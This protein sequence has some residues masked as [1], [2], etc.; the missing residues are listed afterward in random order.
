[1]ILLFYA[2]IFRKECNKSASK[3]LNL[4]A[5]AKKGGSFQKVIFPEQR[6]RSINLLTCSQDPEPEVVEGDVHQVHP[7]L[8]HFVKLPEK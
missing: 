1:M 7:N 3:K 2:D 5:P 6:H 4:G 8:R